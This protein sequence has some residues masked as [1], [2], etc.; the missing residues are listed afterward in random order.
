MRYQVEHE[1]EK[2]HISARPCVIL[3]KGV[4]VFVGFVFLGYVLGL[5]FLSLRQSR[6][7][8]T[9]YYDLY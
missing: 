3:C 2:F 6:V 8:T 7:K 9:A 1:T 4:K 5:L